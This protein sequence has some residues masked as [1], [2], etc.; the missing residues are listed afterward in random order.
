MHPKVY[1]IAGPNGAGKTTFA[2]KFLPRYAECTEFVNADL[3]ASALSPFV[4]DRAAFRA[5][6][7]MLE[8]IHLL[9]D[10]GIDFGFET[11]LAGKGY[12]R[13][14]HNLKGRG[15]S[16]HLFYLWVCSIDIALERIAD[17]VRRGGHN[18]PKDVVRRR[19]NRSLPNL[20]RLYRPL[21][22]SW[23]V[24]DNSTASPN[25]VVCEKSGVL[26]IVNSELFALLSRNL[27]A[28]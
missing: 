17:R 27:E 20:F 11:T 8:Q 13:L 24:F 19:F 18:V 23:T 22:D 4:P 25:M 3:I 15:Y 21:L 16:I 12:V 7:L 28:I 1:I 9:A 26:E 5:G 14:L 10:R 2:T 6:R